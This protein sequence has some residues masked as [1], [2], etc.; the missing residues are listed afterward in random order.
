MCGG[1]GGHDPFCNYG[2]MKGEAAQ[3][4]FTYI[5]ESITVDEMGSGRNG[6]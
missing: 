4:L 6:S 2:E 1:G 5:V 3:K